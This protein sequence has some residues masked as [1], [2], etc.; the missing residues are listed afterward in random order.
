[1]TEKEVKNFAKRIYGGTTY[2]HKMKLITYNDKYVLMQKPPSTE[3]IGRMSGNVYSESEWLLIS[4]NAD[5][6]EI[7]HSPKKVAAFYKIGKLLKED[8]VKLLNEFG[9]IFPKKEINRKIK[10]NKWVVILNNS[11]LGHG[12]FYEKN[13]VIAKLI[14]DNGDSIIAEHLG[15]QHSYSKQKHKIATFKIETDAINALFKV[16]RIGNEYQDARKL[17]NAKYAEVSEF[18]N[19]NKSKN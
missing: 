18:F 1:M 14:K 5:V 13:V 12:M 8:K 2:S 4:F 11:D 10:E 9:I 3:Y 6:Q 15:K 17:A 16:I 19:N 7:S